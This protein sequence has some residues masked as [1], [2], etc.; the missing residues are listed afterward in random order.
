M[1]CKVSEV[2]EMSKVAEIYQLHIAMYK[3]KT[4]LNCM[5]L[6]K[7]WMQFKRKVWACIYTKDFHVKDFCILSLKW[8]LHMDICLTKYIWRMWSEKLALIEQW[9]WFQVKWRLM[10]RMMSPVRTRN[11]H[12]RMTTASQKILWVGT[13]T[14]RMGSAQR[15]RPKASS[16]QATKSDFS[17]SSSTTW[18]RLIW[19]LLKKNHGRSDLMRHTFDSAVW[20][21]NQ[22]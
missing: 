22:H 14:W 6:C 5:T 18:A 1:G 11:S 4:L 15:T 10:S 21:S 19:V 2:K 20:S 9:I 7:N 17:H 16:S 3:S 13:M 8:T 12:Q